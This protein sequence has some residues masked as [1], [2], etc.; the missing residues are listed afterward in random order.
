[1]KKNRENNLT[2]QDLI[3]TVFENDKKGE[4]EASKNQMYKDDR[5]LAVEPEE[6][7]NNETV[8]HF[9]PS[10]REMIQNMTTVKSN[11]DI[12]GLFQEENMPSQRAISVQEIS[13]LELNTQ[14]D[15]GTTC[16][17]EECEEVESDHIRPTSRHGAVTICEMFTK[18][19]GKD[20]EQATGTLDTQNYVSPSITSKPFFLKPSGK[21]AKKQPVRTT[22]AGRKKTP[23]RDEQRSVLVN[24]GQ[25]SPKLS[26]KKSQ[27]SK[28]LPSH[29]A[30]NE[31]LPSPVH[32]SNKSSTQ[33]P[34]KKGN[35]ISNTNHISPRP[36]SSK[37]P[38]KNKTRIPIRQAWKPKP[39]H[40][41]LSSF[42]LAGV[43]EDSENLQ[44]NEEV[45]SERSSSA[46][47]TNLGRGSLLSTWNPVESYPQIS[48][49]DSID[50]SSGME[51]S[52]L[53]KQLYQ[54][55][56]ASEGRYSDT[57]KILCVF[58]I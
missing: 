12:S 47:I 4:R 2:S 25:Q 11:P 15:Q 13:P 53:D 22:S 42:F 50:M 20:L 55:S 39:T 6:K 41:E 27:H 7:E 34:L 23:R 16:I 33:L 38:T 17:I 54:T 14:D 32:Q 48:T 8:D 43:D 58:V 44:Q 19:S 46:P 5:R 10:Y 26:S 1:M 24:K 37:G 3:G 49:P 40:K 36:P 52:T 35:E 18:D 56:A 30:V 57:G 31:S 45:L 9:A 29:Q 51:I 28:E 21:V